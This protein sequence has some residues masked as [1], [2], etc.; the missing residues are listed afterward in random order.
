MKIKGRAIQWYLTSAD[1]KQVSEV[2]WG[3]KSLDDI[4]GL[5]EVW[6]IVVRCKFAQE[7]T[8][9]ISVTFAMQFS[10]MHVM[11]GGFGI[12]NL[13]LISTFKTEDLESFAAY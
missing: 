2:F 10:L 11:V 6:V 3:F 9:F 12:F 7:T 4:F 1:L 5:V 13:K 8:I